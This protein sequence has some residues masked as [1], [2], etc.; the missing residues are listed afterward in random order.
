[1]ITEITEKEYES[2]DHAAPKL[3]EFY[4]KTCGPCKMLSFV[5]KDIAKQKPEFPIYI[6]DFDENRD[7]KERLGV[8]GF[9]TM[10]F[11]KDGTEASR[12][13]GLK[14]KPAIIKAIEAIA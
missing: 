1:M 3:I 7:L 6:I 5:L 8:K 9:P 4:S 12:L 2:L 10:L 14:Q 13:E 11:F